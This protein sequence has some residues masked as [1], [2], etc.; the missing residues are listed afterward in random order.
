MSDSPVEIEY[1][2][3]DPL[4]GE[5]IDR[6]VS[7]FS[8]LSR[9]KVSVLIDAGLIKRNGITVKKGSEKAVEGDQLLF[10]DPESMTA[11]PITPDS[12]V[13]FSVVFEDDQVIVVD[14][15]AG[16]VVHPGA[17]RENGTLV[18]GLLARYPDMKKVGER[19]RLGLVHRL[20]K[21]TSG[22]L[23]VARTNSALET[24]RTQMENQM[25]GRQYFAIVS[26][27][28]SSNK[29]IIEAPLGRDPRNPLRRAVVQNGKDATTHYEVK[30]TYDTPLKV[31]TV[32]CIL[33]TGRTHQIRAHFSAIN[34]PVLGDSLYGGKFLKA[35]EHRPALH[36]EKI[37]FSHP[38][39]KEN[40]TFSSPL[41][42]DL[43]QS[44]GI[45]S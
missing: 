44:L 31:T 43:E 32:K 24:L 26:G 3:A 4:S 15:P 19:D 2:V 18:N 41:P 9:S 20:D 34:H 12:S 39:T 8:G 11:T 42:D 36:A 17:G 28:L 6:V 5:R 37:N 13:K 35:K 30:A 7:F 33:E 40:L 25:V 29:G 22:L 38:M 27:H 23:L 16:V 10:P 45:L 1:V 14:K 21:G